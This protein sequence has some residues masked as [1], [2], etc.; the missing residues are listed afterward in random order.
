MAYLVF[1]AN[2]EEFDRREL[3]GDVVIG[4]APDCGISIHDILLSRHHCRVE[5]AGSG[6]RLVDLGSRNGTHVAGQPVTAH[7]L[8]DGE[9]VRIGRTHATFHAGH[10]VPAPA[11]TRRRAVVRP[12]DPND[13]MAGTVS[14]FTLIEPDEVDRPAGMPFPQPHPKEPSSYANE[15]VYRMLDEIKS[16]SWDSI[17]A[18]TSRPRVM[19]RAQPTPI[20]AGPQRVRP[21]QRVAMCLQAHPAPARLQRVPGI[22]RRLRRVGI[23][24]FSL[25]V[26]FTAVGARLMV[27]RTNAA[28]P[29]AES[30]VAV[31]EITATDEP[32][33]ASATMAP[34]DP[35]PTHAPADPDISFAQALRAFAPFVLTH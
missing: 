18:E 15:H 16:S 24:A 35:L 3:S 5:R 27:T 17:Y 13:A 11:G 31:M 8:A 33:L 25:V 29:I 32:V 4:R 7:V 28:P 23:A 30:P 22:S 2:G 34:D 12:A 21:R 10:F 26:F 1:S 19:Q 20:L 9:Q 6:W 14:G